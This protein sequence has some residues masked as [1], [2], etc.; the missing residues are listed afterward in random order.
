MTIKAVLETLGPD[1]NNDI[2]RRLASA[3]PGASMRLEGT[4]CKQS[5]EEGLAQGV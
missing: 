2:M 1:H 3:Y 5:L 4:W